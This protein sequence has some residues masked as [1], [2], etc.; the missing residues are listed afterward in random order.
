[1]T[2]E[3]PLVGWKQISVYLNV[4][5]RKAQRIIKRSRIPFL[6]DYLPSKALYASSLKKYLEREDI[7]P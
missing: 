4:S 1:M 7:I 2:I 3:K 5:I 6:P